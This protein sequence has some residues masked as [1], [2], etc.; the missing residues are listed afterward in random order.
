MS[1]LDDEDELVE[2]TTSISAPKHL[3]PKNFG[4][5]YPMPEL[6]NSQNIKIEKFTHWI[7]VTYA[8]AMLMGGF[9]HYHNMVQMMRL[10]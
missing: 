2:L 7:A 4:I 3:L 6:M 1:I 9:A 10:W 8:K 5:K